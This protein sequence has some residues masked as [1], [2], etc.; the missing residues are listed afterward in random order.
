MQ[1]RLLKHIIIFGGLTCI[2]LVFV[3]IN[4]YINEKNK[5]EF[6]VIS[7]SNNCTYQ[8]E[9]LEVDGDSLKI[10]GWFLEL[11][12]IRNSSEICH[13]KK[14]LGILLM[15]MDLYK[16]KVDEDLSSKKNGIK[17][18]VIS[19]DRE[20]VDE[21][22]NCEFDYSHC[23]FIAQLKKNDI[24]ILNGRYQ[25]VFKPEESGN[26]GILSSF[27]IDKGKLFHTNPSSYREPDVSG[28]DL[29]DIV[30]AGV[31]LAC[32]P[33]NGIYVYQ[34]QDRIFWIADE[35]FK[36]SDDGNTIII[37][38]MDTT[39]FDKLPADRIENG[40]YWSNISESFE[41]YEITGSI[42]CGRYRVSVRDIPREYSVVCIETGQYEEG[43]YI[44]YSLTR[45]IY[46]WI[47]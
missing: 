30:N 35:G 7:D 1:N 13:E 38:M 16:N 39:Q 45:P 5:R 6:E 40:Y 28:T 18:E 9:N 42:N 23:G 33:E 21:Y 32:F 37:Y 25:I 20:D 26:E 2:I 15:D 29:E 31:C 43:Q 46:T 47:K 34:Y 24:D 12:K 27:Y 19:Q 4:F 17:M 22:F 11:N 3:I 36:F 41:K 8:I 14:K 10:S 44:W